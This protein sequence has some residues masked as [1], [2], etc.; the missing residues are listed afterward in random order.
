MGRQYRSFRKP[1]SVGAY[2]S[3]LRL[4]VSAERRGILGTLRP[5]YH[6]N[7]NHNK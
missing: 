7:D 1:P 5:G 6:H 4:R 2:S 3:A